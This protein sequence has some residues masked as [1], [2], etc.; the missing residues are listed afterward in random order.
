FDGGYR[1][2]WGDYGEATVAPGGTVWLASEYINQTCD[3][4]TFNADS[5]CGN[6]RT[7]Y[8]NWSTRLYSIS[9]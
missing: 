7:F 9:P 6:T 4:V 2:R 3:D 8:A 5:T 1:T